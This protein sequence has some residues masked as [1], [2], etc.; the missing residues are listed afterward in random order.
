M[1][2]S[3]SSRLCLGV[4]YGIIFP[5]IKC[6]SLKCRLSPF[7]PEKLSTISFQWVSFLR[8][9]Q[10]PLF[11][12]ILFR[13][14]SSSLYYSKSLIFFP[15]FIMWLTEAFTVLSIWLPIAFIPDLLWSPLLLYHP[16]FHLLA[17]LSYVLTH[18]F[19]KVN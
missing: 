14:P 9:S 19:F 16:I 3:N 15:L 1:R 2:F 18:I 6:M 10:L 12:C 5:I 4:W 8:G 13:Y 17:Y 11:R 7:L